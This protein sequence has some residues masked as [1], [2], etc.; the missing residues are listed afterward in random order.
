LLQLQFKEIN[1]KKTPLGAE[2]ITGVAK[3]IKYNARINLDGCVFEGSSFPRLCHEIEH[4]E[5]EV[6]QITA[7][8]FLQEVKWK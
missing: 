1:L 2:E 8:L 7:L 5:G 4:C 6:G 3:Q